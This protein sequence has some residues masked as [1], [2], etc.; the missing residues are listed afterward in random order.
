MP[1]RLRETCAAG[2]TLVEILVFLTIVLIISIVG[3]SS[4][5]SSR[6]SM[7]LNI[8]S[9]RIVSLLH[10]MR[11]ISQTQAKCLGIRFE[12]DKTPQGIES[13]YLN[14]VQKCSPDE[15]PYPIA[16]E[17][18]IISQQSLS[19]MFIPPAGNMQILPIGVEPRV[20]M[21]LKLTTSIPTTIT[22]NSQTG[23]IEKSFVKP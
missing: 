6:R 20:T 12:K 21:A 4:Y 16:L 3:I 15:K 8:E 9:D 14:K 11:E 23:K 17:N 7:L 19:V 10:S 5:T 13:I 1:N 22:L 2:F 18:E